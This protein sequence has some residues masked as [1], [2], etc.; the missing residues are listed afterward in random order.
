M[1]SE[2]AVFKGD[3]RGLETIPR[4]SRRLIEEIRDPEVLEG[5]RK[6]WRSWRG[7]S[8]ASLYTDEHYPRRLANCVDAPVLLYGKGNA[9]FNRE[10]TISIV[11]TAAPP[12]TGRVSAGSSFRRS[13]R[14]SPTCRW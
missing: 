12:A 8:S 7:T 2:E 13:P 3:I 9:D 14:L 5:Q 11:G 6:S 4:I 1:G 10:K